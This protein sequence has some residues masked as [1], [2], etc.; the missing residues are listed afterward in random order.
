VTF[1]EK[2]RVAV[3]EGF[4]EGLRP[5]VAHGLEL[6]YGH[7]DLGSR[8]WEDEANILLDHMRDHARAK[9]NK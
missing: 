5:H 1:K 3:R 8:T 4:R 2:L 9:R 7:L 6:M